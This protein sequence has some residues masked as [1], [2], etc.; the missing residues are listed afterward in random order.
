MPPKVFLLFD[1][2]VIRCGVFLFEEG[3]VGKPVSE[4]VNENIHQVRSSRDVVASLPNCGYECQLPCN[5]HWIRTAYEM[6]LIFVFLLAGGTSM[7]IGFLITCNLFAHWQ[8]IMDQFDQ[9]G[10]MDKV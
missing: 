5:A 3:C 6:C 10:T 7:V 2:G 4:A 1:Q 8:L 9:E